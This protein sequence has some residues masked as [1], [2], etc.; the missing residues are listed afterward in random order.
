MYNPN[1]DLSSLQK[2]Y[3]ATKQTPAD[4]ALLKIMFSLRYTPD[5]CSPLGWLTLS[6]TRAT[7]YRMFSHEFFTGYQFEHLLHDYTRL[8]LYTIYVSQRHK[9]S[10][11]GY[12][13]GNS[14]SGAGFWDL[15]DHTPSK[16]PFLIVTTPLLF[17]ENFKGWTIV[18]PI[19]CQYSPSWNN[20]QMSFGVDSRGH[21]ATV[22]QA[23]DEPKY[24]LWRPFEPRIF[25]PRVSQR[26][27]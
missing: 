26:L 15:N 14:L 5:E 11:V 4:L 27:L 25:R 8:F 12:N 20:W 18:M 21:S 10:F 2:W 16:A 23:I 13:L 9:S 7:I 22:Y 17:K 19:R 1:W 6:I 3:K 24:K